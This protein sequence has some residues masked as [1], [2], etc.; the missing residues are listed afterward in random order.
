MNRQHE[1]KVG[2]IALG[3][4]QF[5]LDYGIFGA[6]KVT[7][8]EVRKILTYARENKINTLDTAISYGDSEKILGE[9]GI[10][11]WKTV[12]KLHAIP[13]NYQNLEEWVIKSVHGSLILFLRN[14]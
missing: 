7:T 2:R 6:I 8:R 12:T 4:V 11:E 9:V 14:S 5:G 13:E 10:C 3:T 1:G